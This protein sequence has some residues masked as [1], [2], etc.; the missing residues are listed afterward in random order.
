[1]PEGTDSGA[2]GASGSPPDDETAA[3]GLPRHARVRRALEERLAAGAYPPGTLLPTELQLAAEFGASRFTIRT[4]LRA[5][6]ERGYLERR[7]GVGTRVLTTRPAAR[8]SQSFGSLEELFEF[9]GTTW[10]V[11]HERGETV[12]GAEQAARLGAEP[13]ETWCRITGV[14]WTEPGGRPLCYIESLIPA[15]YAEIVPTLDPEAGPFFAQLERHA[16]GPIDEV[17]QDVRAAQMPDAACRA[18]GQL[19]GSWSLQILRRYL[20]TGGVLIASFN[21]HPAGQLTYTMRIRRD[22]RPDGAG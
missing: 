3:D 18:L 1:M 8:Y 15:R 2:S 11:M 17:V 20:T 13:G 6:T 4:A 22:P 7:Q 21:W 5:L 12:L 9:A 16:E 10:Y 14:R 19:P